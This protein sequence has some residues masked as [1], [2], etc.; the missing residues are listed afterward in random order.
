M[1]LAKLSKDFRGL[2][3]VTIT[4]NTTNID[5]PPSFIG[6]DFKYNV[7]VT[8]THYIPA[9]RRA[10]ADSR[11]CDGGPSPSPWGDGPPSEPGSAASRGHRGCGRLVGG[12][13]HQ[14]RV[15][16]LELLDHRGGRDDPVRVGLPRRLLLAQVPAALR[17]S[18]VPWLWKQSP[19]E[20]SR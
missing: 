2:T 13:R 3:E 9:G 14:L 1:T 8:G 12:R 16:L 11:S 17:W 7:Y 5:T 20:A 19:M 15:H 18:G 4:Y 6:D 10:R